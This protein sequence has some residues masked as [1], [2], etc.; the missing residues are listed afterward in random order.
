M[1]AGAKAQALADA[2]LGQ[3][4]GSVG[5][6]S[7]SSGQL[8]DAQTEGAQGG[9][10]S[11]GNRRGPAESGPQALREIDGVGKNASGESGTRADDAEL[12]Q[13]RSVEKESWFAKL[14]PETRNAIRAKSQ[15]RAPRS[16]EEKLDTYFKNID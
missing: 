11:G 15:R 10:G 3:A 7:Q 4:S 5:A 14:P 1:I 6:P 8:T 2:L 9:G 16:Y 12:H 13:L